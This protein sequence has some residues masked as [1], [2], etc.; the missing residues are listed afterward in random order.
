DSRNK[1]AATDEDR[2]DSVMDELTARA[3]DLILESPDSCSIS[4]FQRKLSLGF[5]KAGRLMDE[6]EKRGIVGPSQGS[7]PRKVL[8]SR[9]DWLEMNALAGS[10]PSQSSSDN[11]ASGTTQ[12]D[13]SNGGSYV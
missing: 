7:K 9:S 8:I 4:S 6:L 10:S 1:E 3:V 11:A 2:R 5:S 13:K 12:T